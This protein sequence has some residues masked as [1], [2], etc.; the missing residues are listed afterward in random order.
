MRD[1]SLDLSSPYSEL[2]G[3]MV[4]TEYLRAVL[5]FEFDEAPKTKREKELLWAA[6]LAIYG[7]EQDL[8]PVENVEVEPED[9]SEFSPSDSLAYLKRIE[10]LRT[11]A[12]QAIRPELLSLTQAE[13]KRLNAWLRDN[14]EE[15]RTVA[16]EIETWAHVGFPYDALNE[17]LGKTLIVSYA[18]APDMDTAGMVMARRIR[19]WGKVVSVMSNDLSATNKYDPEC[20]QMCAPFVERQI[21]VHANPTIFDWHRISWFVRK[22]MKYIEQNPDWFAQHDHVY[23]R[24]MQPASHFLAA[25]IKLKHPEVK[26]TAEFSDPLTRGVRNEL[27]KVLILPGDDDPVFEAMKGHL[28]KA[29][30]LEVAGDNLFLWD[31]LLAYS[32]ADELVFTNDRQRRYMTEQVPD[33][34]LQKRMESISVAD[35][36][37]APPARFYDIVDSPID[38]DTSKINIGFLGYFYDTRRLAELTDALEL[39]SPEDRDAIAVTFI[40]KNALDVLE[41]N[42]VDTDALNIQV[43]PQVTYF[44]ALAMQKDFDY[45]IINDVSTKKYVDYNIYL[46]SKISDMV[47][48]FTKVWGITEPGSL[49]DERPVDV[50]SHI[51]DVDGALQALKKI[52]KE[53]EN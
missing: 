28:E 27:K 15:Q 8:E 22:G 38:L 29:G 20:F 37:P 47:H 18:F 24:V 43:Y 45:L 33:L 25:M 53:V 26:W 11:Y 48:G 4:P 34:G 50:K 52:L 9:S 41:R 21:K 2:N 13:L 32:L 35:P 23:S 1:P 19:T 17:G 16:E 3:Q 40:G 30:L 42:S 36:H 12:P 10:E 44:E 51:G 46:P 49:L 39:L 31:E 7:T 5:D 6:Y 14:P